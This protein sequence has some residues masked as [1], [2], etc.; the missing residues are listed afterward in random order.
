MITLEGFAPDVDPV[1]PGIFT[2]CS[3][4]VPTE[5]GFA[6]ANTISENGTPALAA[7]CTGGA[8]VTK[9]DDSKRVFAGTATKVYELVSSVWTDR[10]R[11]GSYTGAK[12]RFAQFGDVSIAATGA[13]ILQ[14][15][16][17][18]AFADLAG[19][20][21]AKFVVVSNGFVMAFN[22]PT[23][24]AD[25][26]ACSGLYDHTA[27]T[28]SL[29]TQSADGRL[30]DAPGPIVGAKTLGEVVVAYKDR[31]MFVGQYV[32]PPYIW[33]W[34]KVAGGEVGAISNECIV[35]VGYAHYFI[36]HDD[37][38]VF[39]GTRPVSMNSPL[40][41][42]FFKNS[43]ANNRS[44][45][46]GVFDRY[47]NRIYWYFCGLDS[48]GV[49]N[50]CIVFN[51]KSGKWGM[52]DNVI[53]A[54]MQ[55]TDPGLTWGDLW[56]SIGQSWVNWPGKAYE[57]VFPPSGS[58]QPAVITSN[59]KIGLLIGAP[60]SSSFTTGDMGADEQETLLSKV[61]LRFLSTPSAVT[62]QGYHKAVEGDNVAVGSTGYYHDGRIDLMQ[63]DRWH[64]LNIGFSGGVEIVG[65]SP[66]MQPDGFR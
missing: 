25:G 43:D 55:Y 35:D 14:S 1:T 19:S 54:A 5:R 11:A 66:S 56:T 6:A 24:M 60:G 15:S 4:F 61:Y 30:L 63:S 38:W 17:S 57:D 8:L 50:K 48:G 64:R 33:A 65:I 31:S 58:P 2:D 7:A 53:E 3:H 13:S 29:V 42:W 22:G 23:I 52:D 21:Q 37:F 27:W 45:T 10:S 39:D 9:V 41:R 62:C 44:K 47:N 26:W 32:G 59:H 49:L 18:G 20:P 16:S 36:G 46:V 28:P 12:W 40:R 34:S 51:V